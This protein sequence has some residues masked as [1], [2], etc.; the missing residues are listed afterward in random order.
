[1]LELIDEHG[2]RA[3]NEEARISGRGRPR[4]RL[5]QVERWPAE[6]P[7]ELGQ[8]RA[9]PHG[10]R[11]GEDYDRLLGHALRDDFEE[12]PGAQS[13]GRV[14][15]LQTAT[16]ARLEEVLWEDLQTDSGKTYRTSLERLT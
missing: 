1:V 3:G 11:S 15:A 5:V 6:L 10:A 4:L 9:L 2:I 16:Y 7:A 12:P 13:T 8:Q 14:H